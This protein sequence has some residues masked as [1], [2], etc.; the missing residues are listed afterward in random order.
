MTDVNVKIMLE[1]TLIQGT[2]TCPTLWD[3]NLPSPV[4][5]YLSHDYF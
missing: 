4:Y 5:A 1:F 2:L 3:V